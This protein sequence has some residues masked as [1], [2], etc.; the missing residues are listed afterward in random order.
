[1]YLSCVKYIEENWIKIIPYCLKPG[2][3]ITKLFYT[4]EIIQDSF[5]EFEIHVYVVYT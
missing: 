2:N 5:V 4:R 3:I 1:M